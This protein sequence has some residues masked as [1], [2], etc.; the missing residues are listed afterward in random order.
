M[1]TPRHLLIALTLV[2][3][4]GALAADAVDA[5]AAAKEASVSLELA[6]M[7]LRSSSDK[8]DAKLVSVLSEL[9]SAQISEDG[10]FTAVDQR[11]RPRRAH[12]P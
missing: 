9:V 3:P 8:V 12:Q 1:N 7:P 11:Q 2:L 4:A 5:G 6:A 10:R